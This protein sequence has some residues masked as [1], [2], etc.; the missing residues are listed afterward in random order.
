MRLLTYAHTYYMRVYNICVFSRKS[1]LILDMNSMKSRYYKKV[2][3]FLYDTT[4]SY[5]T[6]CGHKHKP[7]SLFKFFSEKT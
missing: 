6:H 3:N 7:K 2:E 4:V 5:K 1:F